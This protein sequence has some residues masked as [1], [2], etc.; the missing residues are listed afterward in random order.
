MIVTDEL[1]SLSLLPAAVATHLKA[2]A[3]DRDNVSTEV[4]WQCLSAGQA[5]RR[6]DVLAEPQSW[7]LQELH[8]A[9]AH[10]L[11]PERLVQGLL[12]VQQHPRRCA[13]L[14]SEASAHNKA[15][16]KGAEGELICA[17]VQA[18]RHWSLAAVYKYYSS[19]PASCA[20]CAVSAGL[21]GKDALMQLLCQAA[22]HQEATTVAGVTP[23]P[24]AAPAR[25]L[26]GAFT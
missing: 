10:L 18:P 20:G 13:V 6:W 12:V 19:S 21:L 16:G 8:A 17:E 5:R 22:L 25:L 15:G 11:P 24:F 9:S 7:Q 14:L 3:Q 1:L 23:Q 26:C 4:V 2:S